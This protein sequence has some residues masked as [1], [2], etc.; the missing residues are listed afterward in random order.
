VTTADRPARSSSFAAFRHRNYRWYYM[1]GMGMTAS[2]FIQQLALSWLVLDLTGSVGALGFVIFMQGLP[3]ALISLFGGVLADRYNRRLLL[4][5]AQSVTLT[6]MLVLSTLTIAGQAEV[7]HVVVSAAL[8]GTAQ[9]VTMPSRNAIVSAL[10]P[11]EDMLNAVA[12]NTMQFQTS[13]IIWPSFA[14]V[15]IAVIGVGPTLATCAA[16]SFVGILSL[17]MIRGIKEMPRGERRTSAVQEMTEGFR[18]T[19]SHPRVTSV[20]VL[21]FSIG[22]FGLC[23]QQLAAGFAR[24]EMDFSS[25]QAG[26]FVMSA[27]VGATL[28]STLLVLARPSSHHKLYFLACA[29]FGTSLVLICLNPWFLTSFLFMALYGLCNSNYGISAQTIFQLEVPP[30]L[31]GRVVSLWGFSGGLASVSALPIGFAGEH[32]GLRYALGVAGCILVVMSAVVATWFHGLQRRGEAS[33]P[34]RRAEVVGS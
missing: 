26:F 24:T 32:L 31:L 25:S 20:I 2:Q 15:M 21:G 18:Y 16:A 9:A 14:G 11:R 23:F 33:T 30:G 4:M 17:S 22:L 7:W 34:H 28:G 1:S 5:C 13:R 10:V 19:F 8:L 3:M 29:G 27:G 12:L 6:N